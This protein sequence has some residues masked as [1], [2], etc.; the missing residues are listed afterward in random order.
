[1]E[2]FVEKTKIYEGRTSV[3]QA[4]RN[5][6]EINDGEFIDWY[7]EGEKTIIVRKNNAKN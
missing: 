7:L 6:L 5:M 2:K 1:M 4:L 3:P